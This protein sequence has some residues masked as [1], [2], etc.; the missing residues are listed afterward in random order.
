MKIMKIHYLNN[1]FCRTCI[2]CNEHRAVTKVAIKSV[3][4]FLFIMT[5]SFAVKWAMLTVYMT[6]TK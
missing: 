5:I 6:V 3:V 1:I 4:F 2:V